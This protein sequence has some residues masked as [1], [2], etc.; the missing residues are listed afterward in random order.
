MFYD[1]FLFMKLMFRI[2]SDSKQ[3]YFCS[4]ICDVD[5][6]VFKCF[7]LVIWQNKITVMKY[8]IQ[9]AVFGNFC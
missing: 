6:Y 9:S 5:L 1:P 4:V 2:T 3:S 8:F 7:C